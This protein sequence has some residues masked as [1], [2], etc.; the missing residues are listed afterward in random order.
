MICGVGP[1]K[2]KPAAAQASANCGILGK[3]AVAGMDR[4]DL[5]GLRDA[6][7]VGDI[8][9]RIDRRACPAPTR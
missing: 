9:V 8:Q 1:T 2:I 6:D 5:R 4:V 7:D 3:K